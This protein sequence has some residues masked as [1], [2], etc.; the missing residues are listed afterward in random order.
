MNSILEILLNNSILTSYSVCTFI[1][2]FQGDG[3]KMLFHN[4]HLNALP[5]GY[6]NKEV[7]VILRM[8]RKKYLRKSMSRKT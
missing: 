5:G 3:N 4:T 2:S 6:E 7:K 8:F 1:S